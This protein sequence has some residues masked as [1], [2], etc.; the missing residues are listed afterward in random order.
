MNT[1]K[2][3]GDSKVTTLESWLNETYTLRAWQMLAVACVVGFFYMKG[4]H[5]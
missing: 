2:D 1:D 5:G 4:R 3:T